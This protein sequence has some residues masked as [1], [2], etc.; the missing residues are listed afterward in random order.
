MTVETMSAPNIQA[1]PR[2]ERLKP[3][4]W[5]LSLLL[6][7]VPALMVVLF[8]YMFRP[9]LETRGYDSLTSL[10][11]ALILPLSFL[12]AAALIA[13]HKIE[14]RPMTRA[15]FVLRMRFPRLTLRDV[16]IGLAIFLLASVGYFIFSRL[17]LA[18]I[19]ALGIP[20]PANLPALFDPRVVP[21]L[22]VLDQSAGGGIRGRWDILV[23]FLAMY[24]FNI[25]G[26]E[27]W[28]RGYIFP[29]QELVFGRSTW[30]V[31]GLMW[32]TFHL[33]KWWDIIGLLPACLLI[34]YAAQK[35]RTNWPGLIAHALI[36]GL[37][38]LLL[39]G[40]IIR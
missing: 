22:A 24:F 36:N 28:W 40:A 13:Y 30:L 14:G 10:T 32:A 2:V 21:S 31:H 1:P 5:G 37:S 20:L 4:G 26:E 39:A 9:W 27:L 38:I 12:F 19:D 17:G 33:F 8:F 25:A 6:F 29:R 15:E 3:A 18:L 16:G 11:A 7:Y 23:L 35:L 34:A